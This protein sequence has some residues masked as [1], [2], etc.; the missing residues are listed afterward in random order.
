MS[1]PTTEHQKFDRNELIQ[2]ASFLERSEQYKESIPFILD[3]IQKKPILNSAERRIFNNCFKQHVNSKRTSL[4]YFK[5]QLR[6]ETKPKGN[7]S[8]LDFLLELLSR[9]KAEIDEVIDLVIQLVDDLLL[10]NSKKPEAIVYYLLTKAD[11][12]RYRNEILVDDELQFNIDCTDQV[13]NEAYMMSEEELPI[14]STVR[15][16]VALNYSLFL[17]EQKGMVD[18]ALTIGKSCFDEGIKSI[19]DIEEVK[20]KDYILLLQLIKENCVFFSSEKNEE[21][22]Q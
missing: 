2:I 3:F 10:P 17:Y 21:E 12:M 18:D 8:N 9:L 7:K 16:Q 14:T 15:I 20:A 4:K 11:F 13:Y 19:D 6:K 1:D 22:E 5:E